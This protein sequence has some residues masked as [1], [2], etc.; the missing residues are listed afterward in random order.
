MVPGRVAPDLGR[1]R[2][3]DKSLGRPRFVPNS[4]DEILDA[5]F[6]L[7]NI[8]DRMMLRS[9][10]SNYMAGYVREVQ[11]RRMVQLVTAPN[12]RTYCEVGM[13]GGHS[14][15]A[16]LSANPDLIVH[17][18]DIMH[19][20]YSWPV[21]DWLGLAFG[22]RFVIHPGDSQ[23]SVVQWANDLG[24][25]KRRHAVQPPCDVIFVD[26]D[27]TRL[28]ATADLRNF[29]ALA[30]PRAHVIVD[31]TATSPG[32]AIRALE[33]EGVLRVIESYGP[34]DAPS[35][36]NPCMRSVSRG[37]MCLPWGFVIAQYVAIESMSGTVG[38]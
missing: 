25:T 22:Q 31:D 18:F 21:A 3:V 15:A 9:S 35:R 7:W 20:N 11:V 12:V 32:I 26:G 23:L 27:H 28:G 19:W 24:V 4:T 8:L 6:T 13:N 34:Y 37:P 30:R 5:T 38:S 36:F 17:S 10:R 2:L 29:R 1:S 14:A 33:R 16:M